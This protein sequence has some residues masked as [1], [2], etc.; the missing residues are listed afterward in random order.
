[1]KCHD[2]ESPAPVGQLTN[3]KHGK[4]TTKLSASD[5]QQMWEGRLD[6]MT[7]DGI[8]SSLSK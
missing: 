6:K 4:A 5:V 7:T 3:S 2:M 1:M 8:M